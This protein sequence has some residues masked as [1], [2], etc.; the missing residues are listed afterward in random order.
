MARVFVT[1]YKKL[2]KW[3]N[4]NVKTRTSLQIHKIYN[5]TVNKFCQCYLLEVHFQPVEEFWCLGN[6]K[7][8]LYFWQ[9]SSRASFFGTGIFGSH[10]HRDWQDVVAW[11]TYS[12]VASKER[13]K[14]RVEFDAQPFYQPYYHSAVYSEFT[15]M[16]KKIHNRVNKQG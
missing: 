7:K 10:L 13:G 15:A 16:W 12:K 9:K 6:M 3:S 4:Q 1:I 2:V 11:S 8:K 14:K 5:K